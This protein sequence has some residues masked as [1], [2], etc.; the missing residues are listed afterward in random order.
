MTEDQLEQ[1]MLGWLCEV[2]YTHLYGPD[3]ANDGKTPER[4]SYQEVLLPERLRDAIARLNPDIPHSARE[5]ALN[6]IRDL[7]TP[8]LLS[9]NR[10]FHNFLVNGIPVEYQKDGELRGDFVR[11][12]DFTNLSNNEYLAVNQFSIKGE[13]HTRRPD[14]ILF[15]NGLPLVLIELKNPI[16]ENADIWKAFNQI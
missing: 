15:I 11:L 14:I 8:V 3:I 2:G 9:A 16:D 4:N 5:D 13:K 6:Q 12:I 7:N 1:E 10:R